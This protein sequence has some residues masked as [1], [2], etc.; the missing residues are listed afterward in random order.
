MHEP[1]F[2]RP[3]ARIK[4]GCLDW[5]DGFVPFVGLGWCDNTFQS[6]GTDGLD[7]IS[8]LRATTWPIPYRYGLGRGEGMGGGRADDD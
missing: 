8:P 6:A 5:P 7:R 1:V 4:V 2:V 3:L